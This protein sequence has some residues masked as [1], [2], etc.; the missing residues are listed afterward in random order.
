ME[1]SE[2]YNEIVKQ[3]NKYEK[4]KNDFENNMRKEIYGMISLASE[5][6]EVTTEELYLL[7]GIAREIC[8]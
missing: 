8:D 1:H 7:L 2:K 3:L 5:F 4:E 6:M